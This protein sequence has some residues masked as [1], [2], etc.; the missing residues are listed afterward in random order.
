MLVSKLQAGTATKKEIDALKIL[1]EENAKTMQITLN[2]IK[3]QF[4][5]Q[6]SAEAAANYQKMIDEQKANATKLANFTPA[7]PATE[8]T[9]SLTALANIK[10]AEMEKATKALQPLAVEYNGRKYNNGQIIILTKTEDVSSFSLKNAVEGESLSWIIKK[11]GT[12]LHNFTANPIGLAWPESATELKVE[13]TQGNR[14]INLTLKRKTFMFKEL[15]AVDANRPARKAKSGEK[16]YLVGKSFNGAALVTNTSFQQRK[17]NY[18][19]ESTADKTD[20]PSLDSKWDFFTM[21]SRGVAIEKQENVALPSLSTSK[22][23]NKFVKDGYF[24]TTATFAGAVKNA[25]VEVVDENRLKIEITNKLSPLLNVFNSINYWSKEFKTFGIPCSISILNNL[26]SVI[27]RQ[28]LEFAYQTYNEEINGSRL[29]NSANEFEFEAKG[30]EILNLSCGKDLTIEVPMTSYKLNIASA[31]I[32]VVAGLKGN[33]NIK[34]TKTVETNKISYAESEASGGGYIEPSISASLLGVEGKAELEA[35]VKFIYPYQGNKSQFAIRVY[36]DDFIGKV[37]VSKDV[38]I[39]VTRDF[40]YE[41][42]RLPTKKEFPP[43]I[44]DINNF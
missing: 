15:Y 17:V 1:T 39:F 11:E 3:T 34:R 31:N 13:A 19:I 29:F 4:K 9:G 37:I 18:V 8:V 44:F 25:Q 35:G 38:S 24:A 26:E 10:P 20:I 6:L 43:F 41:I 42:F 21:D 22:T 40:S 2:A 5:D 27:K 14:K 32:G 12:V 30:M 7:S 33:V 28:E 36:T 23:Y 16:L